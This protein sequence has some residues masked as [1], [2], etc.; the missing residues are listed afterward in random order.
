MNTASA[1]M[2]ALHSR[3]GYHADMDEWSADPDL[4]RTF[5]AVHRHRNFTRAAEELFVTQP[6]VSRRVLR[7]EKALGVALLE[8]L[9]KT[10]HPTEAG[11]A[12]AAE[13]AALIGNIQRLAEV[14][15]SRRSGEQGCV[16]IGASTTPGHYLLPGVLVRM[17]ERHSGIDIE[18]CIENSIRIEEKLVRNDLDIGFVGV[19]LTN[20]SLRCRPILQDEVVCYAVASHPLVRR[21][22]LSPSDLAGETWFAREAGSATRAL[23]EAKLRKGGVRPGTMVEMGSPESAKVLVRAGLGIS[24]MSR[25]GL[26]GEQGSG[27]H[28]L[29]VPGFPIT[30]P[31]HLALH[32]DKRLSPAM[33]V[34]LDV[35]G[36]ALGFRA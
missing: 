31:I 19:P 10:I 24:Y 2:L 21:R 17:R 36:E 5:L 27:L 8:R 30:R 18:Y 29:A 25:F 23:M 32:V 33:R 6:A 28:E 26:R 13:A 11:D 4:L 16:R 35:A 14:V 22:S 15:R 1:M 34:F 3:H 20:T 7:L 9:G 12:L